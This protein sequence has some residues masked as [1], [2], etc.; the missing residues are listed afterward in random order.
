M[1]SDTLSLEGPVERWRS[2]LVLRIPLE[3]GGQ[4]LRQT[5]CSHCS[6][7]GTDLIVPLPEWLSRS[8]QLSEGTL[9][10]VDDRWGKLN[11]ARVQ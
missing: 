6:V 1:H 9:V 7:E 2:Q 10:H 11:I 8:I 4:Q 3:A 5:V